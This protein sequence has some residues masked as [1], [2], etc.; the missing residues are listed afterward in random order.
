MQ[1][2]DVHTNVLE[3]ESSVLFGYS[4][5]EVSCL[6]DNTNTTSERRVSAGEEGVPDR[7]PALP[8][9]AGWRLGVLIKWIRENTCLAGLPRTA[10]DVSPR[11]KRSGRLWAGGPQEGEEGGVSV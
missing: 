3:S 7:N 2:C 6:G 5:E 10:R 9:V 1:L 4:V 11:E 8:P